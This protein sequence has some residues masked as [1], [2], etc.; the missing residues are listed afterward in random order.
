VL[1]ARPELCALE[2]EAAGMA[3][4]IDHAHDEGRIVGFMVV[5]GISDMPSLKGL[6]DRSGTGERDK[7]KRFAAAVSAHFVASWLG[8][9]HWPGLPRSKVQSP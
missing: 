8:S 1:R 4:A 6:T 5:R 9:D 7:W 2:M 3:A